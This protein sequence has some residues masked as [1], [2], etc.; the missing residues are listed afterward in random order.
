MLVGGDE[1]LFIIAFLTH[2]R[3]FL[4]IPAFFAIW[5]GNVIGDLIWLRLGRAFGHSNTW[6]VRWA[7]KVIAPIESHIVQRPFRTLF[8]SKFTYGI[9][10]PILFR[11]GALHT[12]TNRLLKINILASATWILLVGGIGYFS[13]ASADSLRGYVHSFELVTFIIFLLFLG[14]SFAFAK[15]AKDRL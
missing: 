4:A 8:L 1:T 6:M 14:V 13:G 2:H 7:N 11:A 3:Y 15:F 9:H 5:A 10:R 12:D